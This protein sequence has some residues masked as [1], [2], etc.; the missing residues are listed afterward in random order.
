[1]AKN[2]YKDLTAFF[3]P[4][5]YADQ[6]NMKEKISHHG[7]LR[8]ALLRAKTSCPMGWIGLAIKKAAQ[9]TTVQIHFLLYFL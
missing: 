5:K 8:A 4:P 9:K 1:M 3:T 6:K 2:S 7:F